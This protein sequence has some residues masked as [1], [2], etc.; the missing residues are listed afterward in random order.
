MLRHVP[1]IPE[2]S[3]ATF[4]PFLSLPPCLL[5]SFLHLSLYPSLTS[6]LLFQILPLSSF[7]VSGSLCPSPSLHFWDSGKQLGVVACW[8]IKSLKPYTHIHLLKDKVD[9]C[10]MCAKG[11]IP[12]PLRFLVG[13]QYLRS[14]KGPGLLTLLVFLWVWYPFHVSQLSSEL[15]LKDPNLHPMFGSGY[16]HLS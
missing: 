2:H 6:F 5:V 1:W 3:K 9:L 15:F 16:L 4:Y 7:P 13:D 8:Y 10:Y 14:P 11:L 12:S